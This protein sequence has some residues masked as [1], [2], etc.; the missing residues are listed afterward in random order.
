LASS[1]H[2]SGG[3]PRKRWTWLAAG[4]VAA[5]VLIPVFS[6]KSP[7]KVRTTTVE[8]TPIRAVI[9]T[10]GK[11]E[12]V[13]NFEAHAP[14]ATTVKRLLVKE[15]DHVRK[16]QLLLQL[17]DAD[18]RAQ[19]AKAHA[20]ISSAA[21]D[22]SAL[23]TGGT[24]EEVLTVD[25]QLIKAHGA[26]DTARRNLDAF[27]RLQQQGAASPSEVK[28]AEDALQRAQADVTLLEQKK[29][30]RYSQPEV[31]KV[32]AQGTEAQAAYDAAQN[33][34]LHSNIRAPFD[35]TVYSLPVKQGAFVQAGDLLLQ[36]A[37]LSKVMVRVFIDEPDVGRLVPGQ[38]TEIA[39]DA[40]PGRLWNATV[41]SVP[42]TVRLHG[43][44]NVGEATCKVDNRDLRLLP[45]VNVSVTII[46]AEHNNVLTV[47][48]DAIRVDDSKPYVYEVVD[49]KLKRQDIDIALQNLTRVEIASGLKDKAVVALSA[50]DT[51]PLYDGATIKVVP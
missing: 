16:G 45:N 17:D 15:G 5:A 33:A 8:R 24:Q 26:L 40:I 34:L 22:Q 19:A 28:Q 44:R 18:I 49:D 41:N 13:V 39:W 4:V 31:A 2:N 36:E 35:G 21:A 29:K 20:Q 46:T 10:N 7:L 30:D 27:R 23:K 9:S 25:A 14:I 42:S 11:V 1:N 50:Q 51:K 43:A 12:P 6:G 32:Q 48:R 3:A 38:K 47:Q 37:D